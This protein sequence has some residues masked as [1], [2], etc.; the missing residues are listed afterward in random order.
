MEDFSSGGRAVYYPMAVW[1][2]VDC[3]SRNKILITKTIPLT[4]PHWPECRRQ[5]VLNSLEKIE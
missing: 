5:L 1:G 4:R 3:Y 2:V